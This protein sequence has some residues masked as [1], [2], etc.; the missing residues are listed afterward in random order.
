METLAVV[1]VSGLVASVSGEP[2]FENSNNSS[3]S[4]SESAL[5]GAGDGDRPMKT[6]V[7]TRPMNSEP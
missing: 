3:E 5:E 4:V 2:R 7:L 1:E 6:G